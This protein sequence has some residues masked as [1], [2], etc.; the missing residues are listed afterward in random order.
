MKSLVT[1]MLQIQIHG[2]VPL[3]DYHL[4]L[5]TATKSAHKSRSRITCQFDCQNQ[6]FFYQK[7]LHMQLQLMWE[8]ICLISVYIC[9]YVCTKPKVQDE[10]VPF[11]NTY[12]IYMYSRIMGRLLAI[13]RQ[14]NNKNYPNIGYAMMVMKTEGSHFDNNKALVSQWGNI[15]SNITSC[16]CITLANE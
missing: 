11:T 8:G 7:L 4:I 3:K 6:Q 16:L 10:N 2:W 1:L 13:P 5:C 15:D 14:S 9:T 12:N